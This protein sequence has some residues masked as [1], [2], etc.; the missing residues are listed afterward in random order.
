MADPVLFDE[1]SGVL[2]MPKPD[3]SPSSS[4]SKGDGVKPGEK[5]PNSEARG[6][7]G[8]GINGGV[9]HAI[10][11][12]HVQELQKAA[13]AGDKDALDLLKQL[14]LIGAGVAGGAAGGYALYKMLKG[15]Q[16]GKGGPN[17]AAPGNSAAPTGTS[18]APTSPP[19]TKLQNET[20]VPRTSGYLENPVKKLPAANEVKAIPETQK[21]LKAAQALRLLAR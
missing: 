16:G 7:D 18:V 5:S 19:V 8:L 6:T 14:G 12:Q 17:V 15:R 9:G 13:A 11:P 2:R 10:D 20:E 4:V 3:T 1:T 21:A